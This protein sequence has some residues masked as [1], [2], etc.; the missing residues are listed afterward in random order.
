M[1]GFFSSFCAFRR[2][3]YTPCA[4]CGIVGAFFLLFNEFGVYLSKKKKDGEDRILKVVP[5]IR[6]A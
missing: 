4:L 6:S 5:R 2:Y 1:L 3:L